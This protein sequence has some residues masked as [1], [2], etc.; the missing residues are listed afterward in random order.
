MVAV[1]IA[2]HLVLHL[3]LLARQDLVSAHRVAQ[4]L[5]RA[6]VM[7]GLGRDFSEDHIFE[8]EEGTRGERN[9]ESAVVGILLAHAAEQS[10]PVVGQLE[11]L[12]PEVRAEDGAV[13][14]LEVA[15]LRKCSRH[16][17][18][19][20][21]SDEGQM[22]A[23]VVRSAEQ[24]APEVFRGARDGVLEEL[25]EL[26]VTRKCRSKSLPLSL[27]RLTSMTGFCLRWTS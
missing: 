4:S 6:Q 9:D 18:V 5:Q 12:V 17:L 3:A 2:M 11:G 23:L 7:D 10:G 24:K 16:Q 25:S 15:E 1:S 27:P 22:A 26:D 13:S 19:E 8:V 14:A 21:V 20:M